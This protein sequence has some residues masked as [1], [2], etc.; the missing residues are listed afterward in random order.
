MDKSLDDQIFTQILVKPFFP[1]ISKE[2]VVILTYIILF[3][4]TILCTQK[5]YEYISITSGG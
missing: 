2:R 5:Y 3:I 4:V 1:S